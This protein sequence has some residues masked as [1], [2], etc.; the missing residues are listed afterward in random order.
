M[1]MLLL[2]EF[3]QKGELVANYKPDWIKDEES[4]ET[5]LGKEERWHVESWAFLE[6]APKLLHSVDHIHT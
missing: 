2:S 3:H 1:T 6:A 5:I 4:V